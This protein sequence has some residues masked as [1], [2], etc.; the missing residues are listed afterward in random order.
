MTDKEF[1]AAIKTIIDKDY[2]YLTAY[3]FSM[4]R[5]NPPEA[6]ANKQYTITTPEGLPSDYETDATTKTA[7]EVIFIGDAMKDRYLDEITNYKLK[8]KN[9]KDNIDIT[10]TATDWHTYTSEI[11][12]EMI[13]IKFTVIGET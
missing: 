4:L 6:T 11:V 1:H 5:N 2:Y 10:T 8:I 7:F 3:E 13:F 9:C 12:G